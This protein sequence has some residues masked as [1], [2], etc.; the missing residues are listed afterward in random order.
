MPNDVLDG[1]PLLL[2]HVSNS[3][4]IASKDNQVVLS[5]AKYSQAMIEVTGLQD[6]CSTASSCLFCFTRDSK[7]QFLYIP[8]ILLALRKSVA[9]HRT[10]SP[11]LNVH[12]HHPR[13][14]A[15]YR[16]TQTVSQDMQSHHRHDLI[17]P[18]CLLQKQAN[19]SDLGSTTLL[20]ECNHYKQ[21][22]CLPIHIRC[23]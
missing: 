2:H 9:I 5:A 21:S 3:V 20:D 11:S 19:M 1:R 15:T 12:S 7:C 22:R 14:Q 13:I 6:K 17:R 18:S 10:R 23:P 4:Q 8:K 16:S